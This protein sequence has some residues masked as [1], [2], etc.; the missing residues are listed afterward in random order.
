MEYEGALK[1][2][3]LATFFH[4]GCRLI[5]PNYDY[6][7][8]FPNQSNRAK[9]Y[10]KIDS[11]NSLKSTN[12]FDPEDKQEPI[13]TDNE[14]DGG[15]DVSSNRSYH[16]IAID[17]KTF[18]IDE[19]INVDKETV[20]S[21]LNILQANLKYDAEKRREELAKKQ[22]KDMYNKLQSNSEMLQ[23]MEDTLNQVMKATV[24]RV[25]Q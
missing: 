8:I 13:D 21:A 6:L 1:K 24:H 2:H 23:N 18:D 10:N 11:S 14:D 12:P 7:S 3:W 25:G 17:E 4:C 20:V 15:S 22:L 16:T 5:R 9:V 19:D